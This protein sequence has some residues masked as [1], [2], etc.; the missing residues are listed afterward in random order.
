RLHP[1][2]LLSFVF[3]CTLAEA[4]LTAPGKVGPCQISLLHPELIFHVQPACPDDARQDEVDTRQCDTVAPELVLR[5]IRVGISQPLADLLLG[6]W[7]LCMG[8]DPAV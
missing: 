2:H 7:L 4:S 6:L 1:S 5:S 8:H 3:L